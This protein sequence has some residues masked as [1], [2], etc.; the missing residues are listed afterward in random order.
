MKPASRIPFTLFAIVTMMTASL[1]AVRAASMVTN[2]Y[3]LNADWSTSQNPNGVWSYNQNNAPISTFQTFWWGE[4]GWG[5]QWIGDGCIIKGSQPTGADPWG[6]AVGLS[7]DWQQGDV[8]LHALSI[9]YGGET[10]F[11]NVKWTSPASGIIDISGRAWDGSIFL[12][13][14]VTWLLKVDGRVI[15]RRFSLRGLNRNDLG[16]QFSA[17][18]VDRRRLTRIP[19]RKGTVIEFRVVTESYYGHF[20]GLEEKITLRTLKP[21][22]W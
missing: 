10:T 7:H 11:V 8:M 12:D 16:S 18:L 17:N 1:T 19:V 20:V 21:R 22:K 3:D 14:N 15:A 5:Y 4:A 13:R 6:N 2:V 9:P